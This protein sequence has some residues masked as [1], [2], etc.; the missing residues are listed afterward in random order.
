MKNVDAT[1]ED[2]DAKFNN[3]DAKNAA[4][5]GNTDTYL[6]M[7][8]GLNRGEEEGIQFERVKKRAVYEDGKPIEIPINNP[9]LDSRQYE[10]EYADGNTAVPTAN[11]TA[12]N[13]MAQVEEH[14]ERNLMIDEV[15]DH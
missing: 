2:V 10:M 13:L 4:E 7:E 3:V 6:G 9:I 11:I 1:L 12:E 5:F 8:L 15:E 14:G